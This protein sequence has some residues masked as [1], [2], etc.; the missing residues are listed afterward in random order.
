MQMTIAQSSPSSSLVV[1]ENNEDHDIIATRAKDVEGH[2]EQDAAE[3]DI[4]EDKEE[5]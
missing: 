2:N 1:D 5:V 3:E 4:S